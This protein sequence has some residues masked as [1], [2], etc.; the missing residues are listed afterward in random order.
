MNLRPP[1]C[2][3]P[4]PWFVLR[5]H[6]SQGFRV[7]TAAGRPLVLFAFGSTK[8]APVVAA[9]EALLAR[10]AELRGGDVLFAGLTAEPDDPLARRYSET[11]V[12]P[13]FMDTDLAVARSLGIAGK[14]TD[15]RGIFAPVAFVVD[16]R[17]RVWAV[18]PLEDPATFVDRILAELRALEAADAAL[19]APAPILVIP[20]VLEPAFCAELIAL[21]EG[22]G[23]E[24]SG[25]MQTAPDGK[26]VYAFD[27]KHKKRRDLTIEDEAL[28]GRIRDSLR[29]RVVPEIKKAFQFEATRIERYI[30]ACYAAEEGGH[31]RAHRDNTTKGTAHRRFAV[32]L[33]LTDAHVGGDLR[34]PEFGRRTYRPPLGGAVVFSCSMLHEA[35]RVTGGVRYAVLPFLYDEAAAKVRADNLQFIAEK[36]PAAT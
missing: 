9:I 22:E 23:G 17:L 21:Y 10:A 30:V 33:N 3:D 1:A 27:P 12:G 32:S 24:E 26:T 13:V 5:T 15:G 29:R 8:P 14:A 18:V 34:F 2:G 20:R 4:L 35:T 36:E 7:D 11:L 16:P 28:K 19:E 25:F 31:F 6:Q